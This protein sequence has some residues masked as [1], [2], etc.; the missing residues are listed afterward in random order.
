MIFKVNRL[1]L[2]IVY[3]WNMSSGL[4]FYNMSDEKDERKKEAIR[5][6]VKDY[7]NRAEELKKL[8]K[9]KRPPPPVNGVK[10]TISEDPM[11]ELSKSFWNWQEELAPLSYVIQLWW[12]AAWFSFLGGFFQPNFVK[13]MR[14][15]QLLWHL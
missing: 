5:A 6:K 2:K 11:E 12:L 13:T 7:M 3:L 15:W 9:P 10:R 8:M 1:S 14:S 4:I